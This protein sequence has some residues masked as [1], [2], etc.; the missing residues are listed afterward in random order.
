MHVRMNNMT[1][2]IKTG[3]L[4]ESGTQGFT[5]GEIQE[6]LENWGTNMEKIIK[7]KIEENPSVKEKH[8]P[9]DERANQLSD[10]VT[11]ET[12]G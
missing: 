11:A 7:G 3:K 12:Q 9:S 10:Q 8:N 5:Y 2:N 1:Q 4:G 6:E